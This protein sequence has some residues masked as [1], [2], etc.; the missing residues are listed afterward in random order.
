MKKKF[1][2]KLMV[3]FLSTFL[4]GEDIRVKSIDNGW[5]KFKYNGQWR[6]VSATYIKEA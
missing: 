3:S 2:K 5:A 4:T 1:T 6:Y